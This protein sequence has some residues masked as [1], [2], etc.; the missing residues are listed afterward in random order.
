MDRVDYQA[1]YEEVMGCVGGHMS[2]AH[3]W[4]IMGLVGAAVKTTLNLVSDELA[5]LSPFMGEGF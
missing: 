5:E 1:I 3:P 4:Y 2:E